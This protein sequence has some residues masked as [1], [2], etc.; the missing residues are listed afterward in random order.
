MA[1]GQ[2]TLDFGA[3][4]GTGAVE[5][6]VTGQ[7]AIIAGTSYAEAWMMADSTA[8][9]NAEEHMLVPIRLTVGN[10]TTGVG[11]TIYARTEWRLSGTFNVRWVWN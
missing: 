6:A 1:T 5:V 4:P 11:F 8:D 9:H 10:V 2:A 3:A 7:A